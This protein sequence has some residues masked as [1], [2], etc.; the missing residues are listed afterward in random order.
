MVSSQTRV[1]ED[2]LFRLIT[3]LMYGAMEGI[4]NAKDGYESARDATESGRRITK[5]K[6]VIDSLSLSPRGV[7]NKSVPPALLSVV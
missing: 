2:D 5:P 7:P 1:L 3:P 6:T 4:P